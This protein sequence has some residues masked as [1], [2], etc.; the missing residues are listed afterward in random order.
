MILCWWAYQAL[1]QDIKPR[2]DGVSF[3]F[4]E[5]EEILLDKVY[6]DEIS[7]APVLSS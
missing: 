2:F 7:H 4:H 1:G 5:W 3:R 6:E